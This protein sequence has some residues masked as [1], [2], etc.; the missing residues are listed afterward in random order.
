MIIRSVT[1]DDAGSIA[2]IYA[3]HVLNG[4]ATFETVPPDVTEMRARIGKVVGEG[5]PWIVAQDK[6][7]DLLG[8][9]YAARYHHRAAYRYSCEDSIYL[10]HDR[11]GQGIG[12]ALLA[13]L[14][15][16]SEAAGF[17]QMIALIAGTAPASVALH[18]RA[19]FR[20]CGCI[21][22]VGRKFG[23]WIDVIHM[24]RALGDGAITAPPEEPS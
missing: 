23:H 22:D 8:Y 6:R 4:S 3:H 24:Q 7:G 10:R 18:A 17:R 12:G 2:A 13:R 14:V 1:S 9:A 21:A 20:H 5:S 19:G 16:D 11:L 15:E